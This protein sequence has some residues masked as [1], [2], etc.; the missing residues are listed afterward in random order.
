VAAAF[1]EE[2]VDSVVA[3]AEVDSAE[4]DGGDNPDR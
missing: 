4:E 3:E 2:V 1:E